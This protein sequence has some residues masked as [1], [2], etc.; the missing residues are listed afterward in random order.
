MEQVEG[1][2]ELEYFVQ[3]SSLMLNA[4]Q[5]SFISSFVRSGHMPWSS[6]LWGDRRREE[7]WRTGKGDRGCH[8][9]RWHSICRYPGYAAPLW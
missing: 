5:T 6:A 1:V 4:E 3:C 9:G 8:G 2:S 7:P